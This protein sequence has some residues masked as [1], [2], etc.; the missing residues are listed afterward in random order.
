MGGAAGIVEST[1]VDT[2]F[3]ERFLAARVTEEETR[4]LA[5]QPAE[6]TG[7]TLLMIQARTGRQPSGKNAP[8]AADRPPRHL[9]GRLLTLKIALTDRHHS[10]PGSG[11][12]ASGTRPEI[13]AKRREP[14]GDNDHLGTDR[15]A[16]AAPLTLPPPHARR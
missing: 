11:L 2:A 10:A 6:V 9:P 3:V 5:R 15:A 12:L 1:E 4:R 7:L 14:S 13:A 16:C 8:D